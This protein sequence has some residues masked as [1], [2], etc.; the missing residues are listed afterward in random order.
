MEWNLHQLV[1][2][3]FHPALTAA[4]S[5][6][7]VPMSHLR[8]SQY[9]PAQFT[10]YLAWT[11]IDCSHL[12]LLLHDETR[13]GEVQYYFQMDFNAKQFD[14]DS[15]SDFESS[16]HSSIHSLALIRLYSRPDEELLLK[17]STALSVC[18]L[19]DDRFTVVPLT[20]LK[21]VVGMVP[22]NPS[23]GRLHRDEYF[24]VEKMGHSNK[25]YEDDDIDVESDSDADVD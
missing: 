10:I 22:F 24:V 21:A 13:F 6:T 12:Q 2:M 11:F 5:S 3:I 9:L 25:F 8:D 7:T 15:E 16:P 1:A 17:S 4:P 14:S 20:Q 18:H 23:R 19:E